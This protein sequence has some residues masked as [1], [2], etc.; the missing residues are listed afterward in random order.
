MPATIVVGALLGAG[1]TV[2]AASAALAISMA[3][4]V[5]TP[6]AER[7]ELVRVFGFDPTAMTVDLARTPDTSVPGR[8]SLWFS[9]GRGHARL[10]RVLHRTSDRVV[11]RVESVERG[12]LSIAPSARIGGWVHLSP[13]DLGVAAHE[14]SIPIETGGARAWVVP[15]ESHGP[16]EMPG[17]RWIIQIHGRGATRAE[18]LRG[19]PLAH[20]LGWSTLLISYRNDPDASP[21][22]DGRYALGAAEWRDLEAAVA[23]ATESGARRIV[24]MGWSMG[25]A[26]ALQFL[27]RSTRASAIEG[28]I[29]ESPVIDWVTVMRYHARL[30]GL[31]RI[32]GNWAGALIGSRFGP[33]TVGLA[34][35]IDLAALDLVA[36]AGELRVPL[37]ILH[38]DDDGFVPVDASLALADARPDLVTLERF[39]VARH[40]RLWNADP[41]RWEGAISQWLRAL[42]EPSAHTSR[43]R[44]RSASAG[45]TTD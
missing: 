19:V 13:D 1:V 12:D 15:P 32:V 2:V 39:A 44:H 27:L 33:P 11:R 35:P 8:Y 17:A 36:R 9:G 40:T 23:F 7:P 43:P 45:S 38:S 10:G 30:T 20:R 37:L 18:G 26:I 6:A 5:V 14:V 22:T 41:E 21:S 31:P 28:A 34:H 4:R 29:L 24:L 42:D 3:R 25:A 16:D